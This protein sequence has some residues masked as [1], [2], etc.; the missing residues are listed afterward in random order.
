MSSPDAV[1]DLLRRLTTA[2]K[3]AM[4]HQRQPA[5]P[6]LGLAGFH[7]GCEAL[8]GVAWLGRATVFPQ[9]V[10]LGA[11]WD[12]ALLRAVGEAVST[13]VRALHR[14]GRA[15]LNVWAPV[16]NP[17]RDPRW[18]R[19]EEGYSEDPLM[20]AEL[21]VAYCTGLRGG[22]PDVWRTA[23]VLKHFLAYN[24]ETARD[25][26]DI[27]VPER[28]LHEYELPGFLEPLRA[29][30]AA[31]VMPA[32]NL[33]NGVPNHVHP[34]IAGVLRAVA[35]DLVV[36][37]DAQAP[38]NLVETER[39]FPDHATSHAAALRAGVDSYTDNGPDAAP[40]VARF[41]EAL[42]RG[43]ITEADVDA[44]LG[45]ILLMRA[46]TGEFAPARDPYTG[47]RDDVIGCEAHTRL[48]AR[49]AHSGVVLLKNAAGTLPWTGTGGV[50]V[51]GHL[52]D[53][54]LTDW[55]SGTPPYTVTLAD[56]LRARLG[57]RS[58]TT[59]DGVDRIRLATPDGRQV[60]LDPDGTLRLG[61]G[62]GATFAHQQWGTSVPCPVPV[63]TL[64]EDR[65]DH[66]V[67]VEESGVLAATAVTP[68][69]WVVR[70]L[71]ELHP[72]GAE[73]FLLHS[74]ALGRY[75]TGTADG[76]LTVGDGGALRFTRLE[77]TS[78]VAAAVAAARDA[79]RVVLVLG[80][81]PHINGRETV[82]RSSLLLPPEQETLLRAVLDAAPATVVTLVSSYP[83]AID[84][85]QE[86]A[87]AILWS[88]HA[89]QELGNA[90]A[91]VL[92]GAANP[93]G[94]LPQTWYRGDTALPAPTDYDIIGSGWTYQYHRGE[95]LYPFGHGLS[96]TTFG[97]G[98]LDV[99]PTA[100]GYTASVTVT[101]TGDR[102]GD[103]VVRLF[104]T[105]RCWPVPAPARRLVGFERV[106]LAAGESRE[107]RFAVPV[108]ALAYWSGGFVAGGSV[109][110][111][112]VAG[113]S[114]AGGSVA[115][116]SVAGGFV[117][118]PGE[119][120]FHAGPD[121]RCTVTRS[122]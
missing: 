73:E 114:V 119:Y 56:A 96:Y 97:Y 20:T 116:G 23:P 68:D 102:A 15:S 3:I 31:G 45:R 98:P 117:A 5:V 19:N 104:V 80:N 122:A 82:D 64:R 92:L 62:P 25:V 121:A 8:H 55:Y 58:V 50:A 63:H 105:P 44:A 39:H 67:T 46:R 75:V 99:T 38:S 21:A 69:G 95:P 57:R 35:P 90:L 88:S 83:Y 118:P 40:T 65:T 10:G 6:R 70:E 43:L 61:D 1:A 66:Y 110:G 48:A 94:R 71:W 109:A 30:V 26:V 18:G 112:S 34:L 74:N 76:R 54:V 84:W 85:A 14:D 100:D 51:I 107:L 9:A 29:G 86:H 33:V 120:V 11:S 2:E 17:L 81:D 103:E 27:A 42:R 52:G 115:G 16:V 7:T 24:V 78:G 108:T 111:G 101:N 79:A 89:G 106:P 47:I 13:E 37:S 77:V 113:G 53:R 28:V 93:G 60:L 59:V 49:A 87:P 22:H 36:C 12:R 72:A 41:T 32:Y 91:D 4:L